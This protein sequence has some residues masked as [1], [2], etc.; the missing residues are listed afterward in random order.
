MNDWGKS[1]NKH[2]REDNPLNTKGFPQS[3]NF[4]KK[5]MGSKFWEIHF[6][7]FFPDFDLS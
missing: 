3:V 2:P 6:P 1:I 4:L 5:L 7:N